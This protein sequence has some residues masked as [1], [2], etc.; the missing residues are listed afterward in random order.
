MADSTGLAV[1]NELVVCVADL[2]DCCLGVHWDVSHFAAGQSYLR[3]LAFLSHELSGVTC[4]SYELSTL[5]GLELDTV[6]H[7]AYRDVSDFKCVTDLD[8]CAFAAYYLIADLETKGSD[9]VALFAVCVV[10]K[11]DIS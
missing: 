2:A 4:A 8:I 3:I 10:Q 1:H 6:D 7:A 5:A 11:S 9:D